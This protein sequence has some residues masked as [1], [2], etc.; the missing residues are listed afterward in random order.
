MA[1][2]AP[3]RSLRRTLFLGTLLLATSALALLALL[4]PAYAP[5]GAFAPQAGQVAGQEF[6]AP[7]TITYE[8]QVLTQRRREE[9]ARAIPGVYTPQDTRAAR[10]QLEQLRTALAYITTVRADPY[11]APRQKQADLAALEA[12]RLQPATAAAILDLSDGRWQAVQ[13]EAIVVLEQVMRS[14]IRADALGA[15]RA[16]IPALVS[17]ALP[18]EQAAIVAELAAGFV[19][20]N[21]FFSAD[22]TENAR[23]AAAA[24]VEPVMNTIVAGEMVVRRGQVIGPVELEALQALDL[25]RAG[26]AWVNI[27]SAAALVLISITL[28]LVYLAR[29]RTALLRDARS[30]L[31][32]AGLFITFLLG[33]RLAIANQT[34]IPYL[35]PLAA[36]ALTI[37]GL[38]GVEAAFITSLPLVILVTYDLPGALDLT[39]YHLLSGYFGIFALG[40]ARRITAYFRAGSVVALSG[41]LIILALQ[42]P[43][44]TTDWIN[45]AT[46]AGAAVINGLASAASSLLLQF[47]LAQLLGA[48]TALQLVEISRPDHPLM[49]LILRTAPGTYQHSLQ[50]ANLAEQAA[51][52][53]GAD[54]LLTRV[55]ALYHDLGKT[56]NPLFFIENQ[57]PGNL[58]PHHDLEPAVSAGAIIRHVTEGV[59]LGRRGRLPRRIQD[60]IL[61]HH[62]TMIT[63]YQY[64][65]ALQAA[66]GD[67]SRVEA[68]RF[69]YPGPRPKSRETA[70]LMLADGIE[71]RMRA[72]RP[73]DEDTLRQLIQNVVQERILAG[74]L[75]KAPLTLRELDAIADS[76]H[77]TLRGVFHPRLV[78]PPASGVEQT[79]VPP[80]APGVLPP[81]APPAE[82]TVPHAVSEPPPSAAAQ[83]PP[84]APSKPHA[85]PINLP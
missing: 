64:A 24:A 74:Q 82:K 56:Y 78:Y 8:S 20:P 15:A 49:Q 58:N 80:Q 18:E 46:L 70:I 11:G 9:A 23:Q 62:G 84:A 31:L 55:G 2:E 51:E 4:L 32:I 63:R 14:T 34:T 75:G 44:P 48:T 66:A 16:E 27:A 81:A 12:I 53:I 76:F 33:A 36:Y 77:A 54:P 60:F 29:S 26:A 41:A 25:T 50:V 65:Q 83:P 47:F 13:Q 72:E 52:R 61:E 59:E 67:E 37:A 45:L 21:S 40:Q 7:Q 3:R 28:M 73:P 22:E 69:R 79:T 1:D 30:L 5:F 39:L 19:E 85:H 38:F 35:F 17:L 57:L 68:G 10:R 71:A 42:L 6:R 43:Q